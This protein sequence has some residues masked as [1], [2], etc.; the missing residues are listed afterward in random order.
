MNLPKISVC[1]IAKNA[2]STLKECLESLTCF[3]E[4][5]LVDNNSTDST[6]QIVKEFHKTYKNLKVFES[7]FIGF[8]ALK[9]L[10]ISKAS[11]AW[12]FSIDA[13]EVFDKSALLELATLEWSENLVLLMPRKNLY[14][15]EWI[16]ACGW[17]P[18]FVHR[19]FNKTHTQ[20]NVNL[21]H[22]SL[23][24]TKDTQVVRLKNGLLHYAYNDMETLI[25]KM[26]HYSTLW[27]KQNLHKKHSSMATSIIHG[28]F[29]F[30][31]DYC[32]KKGFL[33]GYKGFIISLCNG[34]GAF[35]KYAKL[36]EMQ[37]VKSV[38]L[39]ITTYNQKERLAL[40]LDSVKQLEVL[41]NEV[42][43]ADDGS[44]EDT[45]ELIESYARDFPCT[46]KHIWQEDKGFRASAIRNRAVEA[47]NGDYII[48]VDGDMVLESHF[49][50][51][52]LYFAKPKRLL[53]GSRALLDSVQTRDVLEGGICKVY[54]YR[55]FKSRRFGWLSYLL[56]VTSGIRKDFFKKNDFIKGTRSCNMSF[57]RQDYL[58]I[59]GFNE[60]FIGW[61]REDSEFV[62]RFLF[63][64]GELRRLKF[65]GIAYHLWHL[66][67]NKEMLE[68]NHQIYLQTIRE[69]KTQW[70]IEKFF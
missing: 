45:K 56:C 36:Y 22:E 57:Y 44:K 35:F 4:I 32:I 11:N 5:V 49:I 55:G 58:E 34:L 62:A 26:Q 17:Y 43:V 68:S 54:D 2:E 61:G 29:K 47:A 63:N 52:H 38:S 21:V 33:Y 19:I 6:Q 39:I 25:A 18:D 64:G 3:D 12:I 60:N 53:Q 65:G 48:M 42:L 46:L 37:C 28:G 24:I 40:V 9:N 30:M 1:I 8:G 59:G 15:K 66:E 7:A 67:N 41:P 50:K 27:A 16:K 13:D 31:R 51:D 70:K 69:Q 10:A 23:E 14:R 20:F